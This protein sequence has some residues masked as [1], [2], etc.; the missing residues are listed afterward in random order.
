MLVAATE[1]RR[2]LQQQSP[3]AEPVQA[4]PVRAKIQSMAEKHR[5]NQI[6]T[7]RSYLHNSQSTQLIA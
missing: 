7:A 4:A 1:D 6:Q 2:H 5:I 3:Q